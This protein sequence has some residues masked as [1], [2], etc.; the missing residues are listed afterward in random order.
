MVS[1]IIVAAGK[2]IRM[3]GTMR[4]QYLD[5]SGR[6]VLAHSIM[7][8]DSCSQVAEIY[9]VVPK[10]DIEY[11]QNKILSLLDLK[12]QINLVHGGAKRQDSVYNGLQSIDKDTET[13]VI[14]DGV[15]PLIHPEE[16]KECILG[17][18]KYGA[19]ILGTPASDTLKRVDKS[20][21]IEATLPRENI[22]L[23]QTPQAFQ[24]DLILKA[25]ETARRDGY[26]GT[27]DASLVER[28]G[29]DVKIIN[30]SRFNI[31]ITQ[32]EDLAVAKAMLDAG[33]I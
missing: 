32:K 20:G 19:C 6:P 33:L 9:L 24:Y 27:D 8:F 16:L 3:K 30:G 22:W 14:H 4:K 17:S 13:V 10:E 7:A 29:A 1:A 28:L 26:V 15:R 2:G 5:L 11:C 25:H 23:A 21:I 12:N 18:K 31:K